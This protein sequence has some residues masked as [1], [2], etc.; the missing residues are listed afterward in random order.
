MNKTEKGTVLYAVYG[1][2]R[3]NNGNHRCIEG[4]TY[5][6]KHVTEPNFIMYGRGKSFPIVVPKKEHSELPASAIT[7]EVYETDNPE[8]IDDVNSLEGY[9]GIRNNP[10]NWYDTVDV[11]T[12]WGT[13]NMF[14]MHNYEGSPHS[15]IETGDWDNR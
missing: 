14:V 15:I 4:A 1:T 6:G 7:I 10:H 5:L 8:I 9:T 12:P 3:Q 2:L 11:A 13:A